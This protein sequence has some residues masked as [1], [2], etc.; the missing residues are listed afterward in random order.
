MSLNIGELLDAL[1]T[2]DSEGCD[3]TPEAY[4]GI[5][6][7]L[8]EHE[9]LTAERDEDKATLA[10]LVEA[11]RAADHAMNYMGDVL[12]GMDAVTDEDMRQTEGDFEIVRETLEALHSRRG[13]GPYEALAD[14]T[15]RATGVRPTHIVR[16]PG[17]G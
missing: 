10:K 9:K 5:V 14:A 16:R 8:H 17:D 7:V 15:Q 4:S 2:V 12:N 6:R 11:L 13:A 3:F 1:E